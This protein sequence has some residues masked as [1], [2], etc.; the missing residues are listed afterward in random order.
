M[1]KAGAARWFGSTH[2]DDANG[3]RPIHHR[4]YRGHRGHRGRAKVADQFTTEDTEARA[5][6]ADRGLRSST[7]GWPHT[8]AR[9]LGERIGCRTCADRPTARTA[10]HLPS[11]VEG[12]QSPAGGCGGGGPPLQSVAGGSG[13]RGRGSG[14][15]G[16][17]QGSG[18]GAG[19]PPNTPSI[20]PTQSG[21]IPGTFSDKV[22]R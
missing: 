3:G 12:M 8:L 22:K 20:G 4:E 11:G 17:G 19:S 15:R 21:I 13:I 6:G 1:R 5:R 14:I 9:P 16:R 10:H 2:H 7:V 18:A